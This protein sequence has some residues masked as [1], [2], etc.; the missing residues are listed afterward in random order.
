MQSLFISSLNGS[1]TYNPS[2]FIKISFDSFIQYVDTLSKTGKDSKHRFY[3]FIL[4]KFS[5]Y[6][7][8]SRELAVTSMVDYSELLE[9]MFVCLSGDLLAKESQKL[10]GLSVPLH[11]FIFYGTHA[12]Y[13][14]FNAFLNGN[15]KPKETKMR[16][17]REVEMIQHAIAHKVYGFPMLITIKNAA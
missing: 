8:D 10:L 14:T 3:H 7:L 16:R 4:Q 2:E 11:P 1:T 15:T 13:N 6:H 9:L 17:Q 12:F 5:A